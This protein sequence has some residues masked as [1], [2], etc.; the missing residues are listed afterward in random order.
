MGKDNRSQLKGWT[1]RRLAADYQ[2]ARR[3]A[4]ANG[5]WATKNT[6]HECKQ[7][8]QTIACGFHPLHFM[9]ALCMPEHYALAEL[10]GESALVYVRIWAD[11]EWA[12]DYAKCLSIDANMVNLLS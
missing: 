2:I 6:C 11:L 10:A 1:Y 3:N 4:A 9:C 7:Y 8:R 12:R 5:V